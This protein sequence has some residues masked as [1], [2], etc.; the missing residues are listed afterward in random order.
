L[1]DY[2]VTEGQQLDVPSVL[3]NRATGH[4]LSLCLFTTTILSYAFP[5]STESNSFRNA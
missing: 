1:A 3:L 4:A 2:S 5:H